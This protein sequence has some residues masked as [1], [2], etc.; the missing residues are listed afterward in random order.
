MEILHCSRDLHGT[1]LNAHGTAFMPM[2]QYY[3]HV[4]EFI[5][6][7]NTCIYAYGTVLAHRDY[8]T[9]FLVYISEDAEFPFVEVGCVRIVHISFQ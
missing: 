4:T 6:C 8:S 5:T 7:H 3:T 2:V 9:F 1:V